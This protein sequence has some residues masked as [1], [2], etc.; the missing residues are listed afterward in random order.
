MNYICRNIAAAFRV[1]A[2]K[3]SVEKIFAQ[4]LVERNHR[5]DHLFVAKE[6]VMKEK[7][8]KKKD[9]EEEEEHEQSDEVLDDLGKTSN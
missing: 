3:S 7:P 8:K 6:I 5:L 1:G 2:G 9:T 4:A